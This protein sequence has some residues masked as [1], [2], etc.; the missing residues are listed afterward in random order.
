[1]IAVAGGDGTI[2]EVVNGLASRSDAVPALG[3]GPLGTAIVLAHELGLSSSP[4]AIARTLTGGREL[5]VQPGR[6]TNEAGGPRCF[7]LMAGGGFEARV[8][9]DI[10]PSLK[11]RRSTAYRTRRRR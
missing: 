7:T 4:A 9:V 5:P 11:H 2:N 8:M 1:M 10:N 6:A 3:I